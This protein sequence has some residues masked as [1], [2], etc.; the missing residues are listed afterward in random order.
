MPDLH[1]TSLESTSPQTWATLALGVAVATL[2]FLAGWQMIVRASRRRAARAPEHE[3]PGFHSDRRAT[4]RR[5]GNPVEVDVAGAA[6][7]PQPAWVVDR[8][9]GGLCLRVNQ[10]F[11][12]DSVVRIR[13]RG[14]TSTPWTPVRVRSCHPDTTVEWTLHC[15]FIQTPNWGVLHQ[16][17]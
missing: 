16:F 14:A 2:I 13:P 6:D 5:V 12:E 17:G 1:W 11:A 7:A 3:L 4:P 10:P 15:Q 8:S 9:Y